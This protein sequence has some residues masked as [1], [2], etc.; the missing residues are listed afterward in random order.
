MGEKWAE[1]AFPLIANR[2]IVF[3]IGEGAGTGSGAGV[4][5]G[6]GAGTGIGDGVGAGVGAG[7]GLGAGVGGSEGGEV[8]PKAP[9]RCSASTMPKAKFNN[10]TNRSMASV[11]FP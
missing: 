5:T 7:A 4:G 10:T 1:K 3:V 11:H 9:A 6:E 8:T 2:A